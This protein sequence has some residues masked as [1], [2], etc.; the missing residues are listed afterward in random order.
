LHLRGK[1]LDHATVLRD[2]LSLTGACDRLNV[3]RTTA[4]RW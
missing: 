3:A 1:W 4:F 2:G